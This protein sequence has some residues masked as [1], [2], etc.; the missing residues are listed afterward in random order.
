M[1]NLP[2]ITL[3]T[4]TPALQNAEVTRYLRQLV[5]ELN[6][7]LNALETRTASG[8]TDATEQTEAYDE[9]VR[10]GT[11]SDWRWIKYKHGRVEMYA[12]VVLNT[13]SFTAPGGD[14]YV[15]ETEVTLPFT[16]TEY[17]YG[18]AT[19]EGG[20]KHW[21]NVHPDIS[22]NKITVQTFAESGS[23]L[24]NVKLYVHIVGTWK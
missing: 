18:G 3:R 19:H 24:S 6:S 22:H 17:L 20:T 23:Q 5:N 9:I 8:G 7:A 1:Y 16:L 2:Y 4:Q 15:N 11:T 14:L 21:C 10:E 13:Q 12:A